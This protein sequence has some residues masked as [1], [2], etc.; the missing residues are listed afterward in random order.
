MPVVAGGGARPAS[1]SRCS[2]SPGPRTPPGVSLT[3]ARARAPRRAAAPAT[4]VMIVEDDHSGDIA[5]APDVSL[6]RHL[7]GRTVHIRSYSKS[8]GPDLRLAAVGG[9]G[10]VVTAMADRRLLGPGL[11]EPPPPGR[12]SSSCSPTTPRS[13]RVAAARDDVRRAPR[14]PGRRPRR[15]RRGHHRPRRHQPLGGGPRR[16]GRAGDARRAG[17]RR[18]ARHAVPRRAARGSDHVRVTV[19]LVRRRRQP[20]WPTAWPPPPPARPG[21]A[22]PRLTPGRPGSPAEV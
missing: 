2:S 18:R 10:D 19:G 14:R 8:H 13:R 1:R 20:S 9:A 12:C 3:P 5:S 4:D 22:P 6:G 21:P 11:V 16:A 15:A 17:H 7:P